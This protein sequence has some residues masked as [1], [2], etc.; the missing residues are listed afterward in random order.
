MRR[1]R[2]TAKGRSVRAMTRTRPETAQ[3]RRQQL[4][5]QAGRDRQRRAQ[6]FCPVPD[7][8][9]WVITPNALR[10]ARVPQ[11]PELGQID[12]YV[13]PRCETR[14]VRNGA[15]DPWRVEGPD[16]SVDLRD[17]TVDL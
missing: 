15:G 12:T 16:I 5:R 11:S 9:L 14:L 7:C 8:G 13:C 17:D 10:V 1:R 4:E 3:E 6:G 2:R